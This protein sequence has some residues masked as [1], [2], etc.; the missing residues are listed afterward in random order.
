MPKLKTDKH[1]PPYVETLPKHSFSTLHLEIN[2]ILL[3]YI[4]NQFLVEIIAFNKVSKSLAVSTK[5]KQVSSSEIYM[6]P[7]K[8]KYEKPTFFV[9]FM[10]NRWMEIVKRETQGR[11]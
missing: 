7:Q 4:G 10:N 9:F 1:H 6:Y 2:T 11:K 8:Y 5:T 3:L